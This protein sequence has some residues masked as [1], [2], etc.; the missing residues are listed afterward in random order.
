MRDRALLLDTT[1]L[2]SAT[3]DTRKGHGIARA[4]IASDHNFALSTQTMREFIATATRP[5]TANGLEMAMDDA[6]ENLAR[7]RARI[8]L[9]LVEDDRWLVVW[10]DVLAR[11]RPAGRS[12]FDAGQIAHAKVSRR[13]LVTDDARMVERYRS[14]VAVITSAEWARGR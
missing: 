2:L 14:E 10:M 3:D 11:V 12:L 8:D 13:T 4:L 9:L 6:L 7:F 1:V 5:L